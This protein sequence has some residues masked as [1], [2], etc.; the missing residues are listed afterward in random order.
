[1]WEVVTIGRG[2]RYMCVHVY[3]CVYR[4]VY[5]YIYIHIYVYSMHAYARIQ[6]LLWA[7]ARLVSMLKWVVWGVTSVRY[8]CACIYVYMYISHVY[9]HLKHPVH[10][11]KLV[12]VCV[13]IYIYVHIKISCA[14]Y[15]ACSTAVFT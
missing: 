10:T 4:Y 6:S 13:Y 1:V 5:I 11:I 8:L 9:I 3:V 15:K 12:C 7:L 2:V 14:Y